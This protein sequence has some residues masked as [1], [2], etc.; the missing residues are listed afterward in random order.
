MNILLLEPF[1]TGSHKQWCLSLIDQ[2]QHNIDVQSLPGRFWKWRMHGA[3][4]TFADQLKDKLQKYDLIVASDMLDIATFKGLSEIT[5]PV[6]LFFHENQITYPKKENS[7]NYTP[8]RDNHYGFINFTSALAADHCLFN[9]T[10]HKE[11]FLE[12]LPA[13]LKQF[14]DHQNHML[15]PQIVAKSHVLHLGLDLKQFDQFKSSNE[16]STPII[17]WNHRWEFDKNPG[18]FFDALGRLKQKDIRFKLVLL[19]QSFANNPPEFE[20]AKIQ[21][22]ENIIHIGYAESFADYARWLW[23]ADIIPV[24][25]H[26]DFFGISV[27]EAIYCQ[28]FPLLPN[29]LVFPEHIHADQSDKY[30]YDSDEDLFDKLMCLCTSPTSRN[31]IDLKKHIGK[32]DWEQM[33]P[34]YDAFFEHCLK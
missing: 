9:S 27:I 5:C 24:T 31:S 6:L 26:Q 29:R 11:V 12:S 30:L 14:P 4:V 34:Q 23:L 2:S 10:Y 3:A 33:A 1:F 7:P 32:Y 21:F 19:G 13:F 28:T 16:Q 20:N 25:S 15:I 8:E 17:L 18:T 22:A